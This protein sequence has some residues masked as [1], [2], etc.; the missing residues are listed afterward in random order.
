MG[1]RAVLALVRVP[2]VARGVDSFTLVSSHELL[3]VP[4]SHAAS[5]DLSDAGHQAVDRLGNA[6]VVLGSLHVEGLDLDREVSEEDGTVDLV[7]HLA[8]SSLGTRYELANAVC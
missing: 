3:P 5:D 6:R 4:D 7:S 1:R 8:L 2:E